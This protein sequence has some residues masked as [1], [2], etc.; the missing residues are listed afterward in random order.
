MATWWSDLL[1]AVNGTRRHESPG[2]AFSPGHRA[3]MNRGRRAQLSYIPLCRHRR[4]G[5]TA[6]RHEAALR[7]LR[8]I[9]IA[10]RLEGPADAPVVV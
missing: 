3:K 1:F 6:M 10:Y 7:S 8:G 4:D 9:E 2:P 5:T